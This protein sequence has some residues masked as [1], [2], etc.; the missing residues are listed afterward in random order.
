MPIDKIDST[1]YFMQVNHS[2]RT[3]QNESNAGAVQD[4]EK[5]NAN[6]E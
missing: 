4:E 5:S 2:E 6:A 3:Q 1:K